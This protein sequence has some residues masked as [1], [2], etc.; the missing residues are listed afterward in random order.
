MTVAKPRTLTLSEFLSLPETKPPSEYVEGEISQKPMPKTRHSRLQGKLIGAIN[1]A[2]E[3]EQIAYAFPELRCTFGGR[4]IIP[5]IAVLRWQHIELDDDGEPVDDVFVAPDWAIEILSP[6]QSANRV[7]GN[8]LHCLK[9]G[10]Q[11]GWLV[12][13]SD[14][15]IIVFQ[16]QQQPEFCH[17]TD[18]LL[19][20]PEIDLALTVQQVFDWL[21][22][23]AK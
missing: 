8:L 23:K 11:L 3:A 19:V 13:P 12:D 17:Q 4:S 20:L 22:M 18:S 14:R 9:Q 2:A 5:D 21:S 6:D 15:S 1:Q 16:P 7:T 10:C